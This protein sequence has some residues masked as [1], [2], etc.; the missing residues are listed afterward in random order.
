[1]GWKCIAIHWFVLQRRGLRLYRNTVHCIVIA[2]A[3]GC[4]TVSR[5]RATTRPARPRHGAGACAA[6]VLGARLGARGAR[7]GARHDRRAGRGMGVGR[8][9][10]ACC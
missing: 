6:G 7:L 2:G 4:W 10:W 3:V 5:H 8:A 9:V 1:M